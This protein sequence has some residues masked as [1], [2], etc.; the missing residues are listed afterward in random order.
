MAGINPAMTQKER[1]RPASPYL[2]AHADRPGHDEEAT[3]AAISALMK[4]TP[5]R[6]VPSIA[7]GN[8]CTRLDKLRPVRAGIRGLRSGSGIVLPG[9]Y[10]VAGCVSRA[11]RAKGGVQAVW[12]LVH[13]RLEGNQRLG[14]VAMLQQHH[15][16]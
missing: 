2:N 7:I 4:P 8:K 15:T 13:R 3:D 16:I 5:A 10:F 14:R 1:L 9:L 12:L 11:G 6:R